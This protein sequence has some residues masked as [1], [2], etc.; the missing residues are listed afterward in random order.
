MQNNHSPRFE[1]KKY[2][3]LGTDIKDLDK[4]EMYRF[5]DVFFS[6]FVLAGL[7]M[8]DNPQTKEDAIKQ[9]EKIRSCID[10]LINDLN[11]DA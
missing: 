8:S 3:D 4:N 7:P 11:A 9:L 6:K 10:N 5:S 1:L 2:L